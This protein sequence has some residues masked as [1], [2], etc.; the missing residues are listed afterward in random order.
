MNTSLL[1]NVYRRLPVCLHAMYVNVAFNAFLYF[2][3]E[4]DELI[5]LWR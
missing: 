3:L 2:G 1:A 4:E 5:R